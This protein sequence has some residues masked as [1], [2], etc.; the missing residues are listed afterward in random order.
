VYYLPVVIDVE[1]IR[2]N[3]SGW[4]NDEI[5]KVVGWLVK[6]IATITPAAMLGSAYG[7]RKNRSQSDLGRPPRC[8][9]FS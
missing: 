3:C 8:S 1:Q 7:V 2:N 5:A 4:T 6:S 9:R